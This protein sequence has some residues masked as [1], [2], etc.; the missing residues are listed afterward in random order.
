MRRSARQG[1][2]LTAGMTDAVRRSEAHHGRRSDR[3]V[4]AAA[5]P[6]WRA[7]SAISIASASSAA[8]VADGAS[9]D[10]KGGDL[11][12]TATSAVASNAKAQPADGG[13][14]GTNLGVGISV[15]VNVVD[16]QASAA[17]GAGVGV[18]NA[19]DL[20]LTATSVA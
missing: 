14:S 7:R 15:A 13:A 2:T 3:P 18:A 20:T 8:G 12:L 5:R 6:A 4:R 17:I 16:T 19:D 11:G 9:L 1:I 10:L